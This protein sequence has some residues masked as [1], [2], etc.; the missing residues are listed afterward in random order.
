MGMPRSKRGHY[1]N[2]PVLPVKLAALLTVYSERLSS[3]RPPGEALM[4]EVSLHNEAVLLDE[5]ADAG[6]LIVPVLA[7][8]LED[9]LPRAVTTGCGRS[10]LINPP[11][12]SIFPS[13]MYNEMVILGFLLHI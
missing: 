8:Q 11:I 12:S 3:D 10:S 6:E 5:L 2:F 9:P 1:R 4:P 7:D 13:D